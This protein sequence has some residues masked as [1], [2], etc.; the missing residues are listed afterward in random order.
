M[1]MEVESRTLSVVDRMMVV[2][3]GFSW[4][5]D[6][7][8]LKAM[9]VAGRDLV[10]GLRREIRCSSTSFTELSIEMRCLMTAYTLSSNALTAPHQQNEERV[11]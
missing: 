9:R 4:E 8:R 3:R 10:G 11:E 7:F 6:I 1:E 5:E 2:L